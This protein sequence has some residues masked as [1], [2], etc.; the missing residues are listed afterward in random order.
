VTVFLCILAFLLFWYVCGVVNITLIQAFSSS[1]QHDFG[2]YERNIT[3]C[4]CYCLGLFG[5]ILLLLFFF[6]QTPIKYGTR[7]GRWLGRKINPNNEKDN[8]YR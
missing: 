1:V 5:T 7:F 2:Q 8:Y 3:L 4:L 6:G